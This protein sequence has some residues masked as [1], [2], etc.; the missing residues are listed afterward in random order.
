MIKKILTYAIMWLDQVYKK[1]YPTDKNNI[2]M[3]I[4]NDYSETND[5]DLQTFIEARS[6]WALKE[7]YTIINSFYNSKLSEMITEWNDNEISKLKYLHI[8]LMEMKDTL[9]NNTNNDE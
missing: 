9:I 8:L 2:T 6:Y 4:L 3:Q 1:H 5:I 7:L